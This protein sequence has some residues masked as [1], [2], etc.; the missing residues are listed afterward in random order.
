MPVNALVRA[1]GRDLRE[2]LRADFDDDALVS[3]D[4]FPGL[5]DRGVLLE[6]EVDA[7]LELQGL[8]DRVGRRGVGRPRGGYDQ[9]SGHQ[10]AKESG[11]GVEL[12]VVGWSKKSL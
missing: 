6:G 9:G 8:G 10:A 5:E 1:R 2:R 11:H 3:A 4:F 7:I 12:T